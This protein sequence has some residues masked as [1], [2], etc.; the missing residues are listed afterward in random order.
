MQVFHHID[1]IPSLLNRTL[2]Q[3]KFALLDVYMRLIP[4]DR[5]PWKNVEKYGKICLF[6]VQVWLDWGNAAWADMAGL[7]SKGLNL[8]SQQGI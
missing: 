2:Q 8:F 6:S 5:S 4:S 7:W 3:L 1:L